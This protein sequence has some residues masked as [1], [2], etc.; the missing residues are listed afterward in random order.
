CGKGACGSVGS[1]G[2]RI[3]MT[4][5]I[6]AN[7]LEWRMRGERGRVPA[8]RYSFLSAPVAQGLAECVVCD[9]VAAVNQ[10][11]Q[12]AAC[13]FVFALGAGLEAGQ[14]LAQAVFD[15]LVVA[16]LEMQPRDRLAAAPVAAIEGVA[17]AQAD[18]AGDR[19][20]P[21]FGN[22]AF[23]QKQHQRAR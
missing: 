18:R 16:G 12:E 1:C 2:S 22:Y 6:A 14:S 21:A 19:L 15:A 5:M 10:G 7:A 9:P 20:A 17:T 13:E 4:G 8:N 3:G 23:G 11:R